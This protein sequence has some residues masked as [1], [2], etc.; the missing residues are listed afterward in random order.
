MD[1]RDIKQ[2]AVRLRS[3]LKAESIRVDCIVLFGSYAKSM[4]G[5]ESDIDLAVISRDF[6][7]DRFREGTF[8]NRVA[9][10]VHP[11]IEAIPMGLRD[12]LDPSP[13]APIVH[14]IKQT[15]IVLL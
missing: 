8:L 14:E 9:V 5:P 3:L 1:L 2:L 4:A 12:F 6:G 11:D 10:K 7:Q 15:G 13:I